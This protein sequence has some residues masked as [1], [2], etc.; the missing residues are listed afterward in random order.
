MAATVRA[1]KTATKRP[2]PRPKPPSVP[3]PDEPTAGPR[4]LRL[5]S[6][7]AEPIER[8]PIFYIDDVEY[9]IPVRMRANEA[10]ECLH[11]FRTRGDEVATDFLLE[12]LLGKD[13]YQALLAYDGL[14][15][16]HLQQIIEIATERMMGATEV[17]K[18]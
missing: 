11:V 16:E 9:T 10:L 12:K 18:A 13:G 1:T 14:E 4:V 2:A 8:E 15:P 6:G 17:P 5:K 3:A 7:R